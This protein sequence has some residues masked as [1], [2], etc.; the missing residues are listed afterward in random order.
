MT[1]KASLDTTA[2]ITTISITILFLIIALIPFWAMNTDASFSASL[3]SSI[4]LIVIYSI[5]YAF[6]P[7]SYTLDNDSILINRPISNII[8]KKK[9]IQSIVKL[10]KEDLRCSIR[11]FG[12]GGLF[13]YFGKFSNRKWGTMTW[14]ITRRDKTILISK[15]KEKIS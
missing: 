10:N 12:V 4:L 1:F 15:H 8:I 11:T 7:Q 2:R 13:G 9:D 14:Y 5:T 3:F 6:C